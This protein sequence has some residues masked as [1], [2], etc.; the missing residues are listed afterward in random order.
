MVETKARYGIPAFDDKWSPEQA[1]LPL[2]Q[3]CA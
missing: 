2:V 1:D 3:I